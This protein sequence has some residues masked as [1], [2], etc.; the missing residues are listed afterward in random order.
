MVINPKPLRGD[1]PSRM[2]S[3]CRDEIDQSR[4]G[5]S[6]RSQPDGGTGFPAFAEAGWS[7]RL[8]NIADWVQLGSRGVHRLIFAD[9][10]TPTAYA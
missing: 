5:F 2:V 7:L 9:R 10:N 8:Q 6:Y 1:H 3:S 4:H